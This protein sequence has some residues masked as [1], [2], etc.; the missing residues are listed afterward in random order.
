MYPR[1]EVSLSKLEHNTRLMRELCKRNG[2]DFWGVTKVFCAIPEAAQAIVDGGASMLA[3]SRVENLIKI[4]DIPVKKVLLRIPMHYEVEDVVE[5]ADYSLNSELSTLKLLG[6]AAIRK[7]KVH[8]VI[9]MVDLGDLR[10]GVWPDR[11]DDFVKEA[12]DIKGVSIRGFGVNLTCYGGVIPDETNLGKLVQISKDMEIK[13]NLQLEIISGGNSS[14]IYLLQ[15][16]R[17][18]MGINNLR[19]GEILVLGRE[20]TFGNQIEG[21]NRDV[22]VLKGQVVEVKEKP[23][24]P[25]G[26]IGMDAF[27]NVPSYEDR[28]VMR[29]AIIA[30]GR[31]DIDHA[32]I[33]PVDEKI[34]IIGASSD[35]TIIDITNTEK[36]YKVGDVVEFYME[37]GCLLKATT[38]PYVKKIVVE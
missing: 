23:S 1:V 16:G 13:Y 9:I 32:L 37:Y 4:K 8:S 5:Y 15:E 38:S 26:N 11:I 25:I 17:L 34:E 27:G 31:Q 18:P 19:L 35:H 30:M 33:H 10:E 12:S 7:N 2:V 21:M 6:E 20:T 14:S 29:R 28:G 36:E 3:D 24:F 22:F